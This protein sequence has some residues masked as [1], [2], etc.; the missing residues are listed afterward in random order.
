[1]KQWT[2]NDL[3]VAG[4]IVDRLKEIQERENLSDGKLLDLYPDIGS[5]RT[6][7]RW[8]ASDFTQ[9]NPEKAIRRLRRIAAIL[10]G[11]TP[12]D[13][14]YMLPFY[15]ELAARVGM[16]ERA[17]T[18]RRILV[19]LA[20]NGTGKT[21]SARWLVEKKRAAR[22]YCRLRPAWRNKEL[23]IVCGI[24]RS[25]GLDGEFSNAAVAEQRL[26]EGLSSLPV[27]LFLDQAHEGGPALMHLLRM[28]VD[29]TQSRF[30]YLGYDT[31]FRHVQAA[32]T[33]S[34]IEARAFLG[35]CLKPIFDDYRHGVQSRD[36]KMFLESATGMSAASAS[37]LSGRIAPILQR[38]TNLRLLD[39]A[40]TAARAGAD[41]DD[42]TPDRIIEEVYWLAGLDPKEAKKAELEE[43]A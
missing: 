42:P 27:T 35:R 36:V 7:G 13:E 10:D 14:L 6:W 30:V 40:I 32:T 25:L 8:R 3:S 21:T 17:M 1:M 4:P 41:A 37:S 16:L 15:R 31:A 28:L 20:P 22:K 38:T 33:D 24:L 2:Q 18:D 11:G 23:H 43:A 9:S 19:V 34:M 5:T 26:V 29:E 12:V 39:D